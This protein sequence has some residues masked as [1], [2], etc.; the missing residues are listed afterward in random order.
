MGKVCN[1][2]KAD[3]RADPLLLTQ[4]TAAQLA[5]CSRHYPLAVKSGQ[6]QAENIGRKGH[7]PAGRHLSV[8][9]RGGEG[10]QCTERQRSLGTENSLPAKH[11]IQITTRMAHLV[12]QQQFCTATLTATLQLQLHH[13]V[14]GCSPVPVPRL[15]VWYTGAAIAK[16]T[17]THR[18]A[19]TLSLKH[20]LTHTGKR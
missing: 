14:L 4:H 11:T 19:H 1:Q 13:S 6:Q 9:C 5:N 8:Q 2:K 16:N 3:Q 20:T 7:F 15:S 10:G 12:Q 17:R 18:P